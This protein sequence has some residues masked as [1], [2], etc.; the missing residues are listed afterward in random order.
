[1]RSK[2]KKLQELTIKDNF[3]FA[4]VM[5]DPENCRGFLEMLLEI[6]IARVEVSYEK[7]M[8]YRPEYKGVRLD[9]FAK[10]EHNTRYNVEMQVAKRALERRSRYYHGQM[11]MEMLLSGMD[12]RQL[13][14]AYVIFICDFDP[15]GQGR[16]L[17][18]VKKR[19]QELP[20]LP[21]EDGNTTMFLSTCG[22]NEDEVPKSL[23][24]FLRFVRGSGITC[25]DAFTKQLQRSVD[26]VKRNRD[27]EERF[28]VLDDM[29][30]DAR[31]EG[32]AE[33]KTEAVLD[34]LEELGVVPEE[35][36]ERILDEPDPDV[37]GGWIRLAVKSGSVEQ[38]IKEAF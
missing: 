7:S 37:L 16:Y 1:M 27:M 11:D 30:E 22:K 19:C 20:E 13:P 18:T 17:Y 5:M 35:I 38:F 24:N 31:R 32:K 21:Y 33:G 25:E 14:N 10:D 3:M 29:M 34:I 4:A 6:P 23:V 8:V 36:R 26:L 28:M 2:K 12:Y 15:F 9:V